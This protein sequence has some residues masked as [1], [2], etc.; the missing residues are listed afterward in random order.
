MRVPTESVEILKFSENILILVLPFISR[1]PHN[2]QRSFACDIFSGTKLEL[3]DKNQTKSS[4][5]LLLTPKNFFRFASK[6]KDTF[7]FF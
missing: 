6:L 2:D 3:L 5:K 4:K 1:K 7:H